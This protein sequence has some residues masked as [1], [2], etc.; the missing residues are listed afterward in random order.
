MRRSKWL[1]LAL[2]VALTVGLTPVCSAEWYTE[3]QTYIESHGVTDGVPGGFRPQAPVTR[4]E[5]AYGFYA[6]AG[7]PEAPASTFADVG[8]VA[9]Y[10][11]A[12]GWAQSVGLAKGTGGNLFAPANSVTRAELATM[13]ERYLV[14]KGWVSMPGNLAAFK[15]GCVNCQTGLSGFY[16][17]ATIPDWARSGMETC[18]SY[19]ILRGDTN[20]CLVPMGQCTWAELAQV[21]QRVGTLG[22][23]GTSVPEPE[24][25]PD[26]DPQPQ[27]EPQP[28][29]LVTK[30]KYGNALTGVTAN[31][32]AALGAVGGDALTVTIDGRDVTLPYG[33]DPLMVDA[34]EPMAMLGSDGK[35]Q[36]C[37]NMGSFW[38]AYQLTEQS[39]IT[40]ALGEKMAYRDQYDLRRLSAP[41]DREDYRSD[42]AY[43]NFREVAVG[44]VKAGVLYRSGSPIDPAVGDRRLTADTLLDAA[45][46]K[47]VV[48]LADCRFRFQDY[49]GYGDTKYS[50]RSIVALNMGTDFLSDAFS[51]DMRNGLEFITENPGP[52]LIHGDRGVVR[53]GYVLMVLEALMG[54]DKDA[55]VADYMRSFE[56]YYQVTKNSAAWKAFREGC[57]IPALLTFTGAENEAALG[58]LDLAQAAEDYLTGTVGLTVDQVTL[59][60]GHLSGRW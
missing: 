12:V 24:P 19:G 60:R 34:G 1:A 43:A 45:G 37:V 46:V 27:P 48:N 21:L 28:E 25:G 16:D 32:L 57:A 56:D 18:V 6:L 50:G 22:E 38:N 10:A 41:M 2:A 44:D 17:G 54:A 39:V 36:L 53:T 51:E 23:Q 8:A 15:D 55:L 52:Y 11:Q 9:W 13:L 49:A 47:T 14:S 20:S 29:A 7:K 4:A 3:A 26:P 5:V 40:V 58:K 31:D 42:A 30:D 59:L 35:L 33:S